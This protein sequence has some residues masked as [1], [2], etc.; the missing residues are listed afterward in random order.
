[1]RKIR[2]AGWSL[3]VIGTLAWA[4]FSIADPSSAPPEQSTHLDRLPLVQLFARSSFPDF[5]AKAAETGLRSDEVDPGTLYPDTGSHTAIEAGKARDAERPLATFSL[6]SDIHVQKSDIE[7]QK[8][9]VKALQDHYSIKPD[10]DMLILNGD[11]TNGLQEDFDTLRTLLD[12]NRHAPVQATMG[13]HEYY[14]MWLHGDHYDYRSLGAAWSSMQAVDQFTRFFSYDKP[15]HETSVRGIPFLFMSGEA[16]RDVDETIGE[17]AYLS[18]EQLDWLDERLAAH[19]AAGRL[20]TV[21]DGESSETGAEAGTTKTSP[22]LPALVFLHQPLPGTLPGSTIERS[23]VQHERLR[24]ILDK[25]PFAVLFSGHTHWDLATTE[26]VWQG[27]FAAVGSA[28]VRLVY[29]TDNQPLDPVKSE[30]LV[31]VVYPSRIVVQGLDHGDGS[32][33]GEKKIISLDNPKKQSR[34]AGDSPR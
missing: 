31:V 9:F 27:A 34:V 32:R 19:Q 28:S 22:L 13:N 8:M 20:Q 1:M 21:A 16:Y 26:Q 23:V 10:A 30:S 7:S 24:A 3:V 11:L 4:A 5:L 12:Q 25:Y 17:D 14:R 6:L 15:Y 33:I 2:F 29:G 18:E